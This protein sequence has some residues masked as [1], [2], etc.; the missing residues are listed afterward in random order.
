MSFTPIN[1]GV[2]EDLQA[3]PT[4]LKMDMRS[5]V[6][7]DDATENGHPAVFLNMTHDDGHEF[8]TVMSMKQF[9]I[10]MKLVMDA[11]PEQVRETFR[12]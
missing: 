6:V 11:Y 9:L 12:Y 4:T 10:S 7:I 1:V 2:H 8:H 5:I 3:M